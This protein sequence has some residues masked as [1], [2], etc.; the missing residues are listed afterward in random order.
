[1]DEAFRQRAVGMEP[2]IFALADEL[3][4][5]LFG[6]GSPAVLDERYTRGLP[7]A[8]ICELLDLPRADRPGFIVLANSLTRLTGPLSFPRM[9]DGIGATQPR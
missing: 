8:V 6:D 3:A 1:V 2:R 5:D 7:L 4:A 9:L